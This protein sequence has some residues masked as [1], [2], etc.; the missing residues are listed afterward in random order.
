MTDGAVDKNIV[1]DCMELVKKYGKR[2]TINTI[3]FGLDKKS[4]N[5]NAADNLEALANLSK[6]GAFKGYTNL[7]L[8]KMASEVTLPTK[9]TNNTNFDYS[10]PRS[11][12]QE[13][14][15]EVTGLT[16]E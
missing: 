5:G 1:T 13:K 8:E 4:K 11:V 10:K 3:G 14:E 2:V 16:I 6:G 12:K 15:K 7:E 9:F